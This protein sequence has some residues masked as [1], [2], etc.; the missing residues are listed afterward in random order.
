MAFLDI[1]GLKTLWLQILARINSINP[2]E[3]GAVAKTGDTMSGTLT[4]DG[5]DGQ[6]SVYIHRNIGDAKHSEVLQITGNGGAGIYLNKDNVTQNSLILNETTS[7]L[8]KP[9]TL[10]SGGTGASTPAA[11]LENLGAFAKTGGT[12]TGGLTID[13]DEDQKSF[14]I[15]RTINGS[16][17][18][19]ALQI[20]GEG[21]TGIYLTQNNSIV[22]SLILTPTSTV[23][24]NPLGVTSGGTGANTVE[25]ARV[26]LGIT[27]ANIG[28]VAKTG[29]TLSGDL[30]VDGGT[31]QKTISVIRTIDDV[32]HSGIVQITGTGGAGVYLTK[33]GTIMNS[34]I[35]TET[36][37]VLRKPLT[38]ASGGT[39]G[40]TK[41]TARTNL[42]I[43]SGTSL[44]DAANYAQGDIFVLYS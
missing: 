22:N 7:V 21:N 20:T 39:G 27:P 33:D 19:M 36:A 34:L 8:R 6:K 43:M 16:A 41:E 12:I 29:D 35:L 5:G 28:A 26:N 9:L 44:P 37:S 3:I 17:C 13:S 18:K 11:A 25:E 4:I 30:K 2:S 23:L 10:A 15:N 42:G 31:E 14:W 24:R 1:E 32:A 40:T 38:L